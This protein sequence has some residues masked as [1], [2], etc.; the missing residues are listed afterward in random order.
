MRAFASRLFIPVYFFRQF[1]I[2]FI[3]SSDDM[4]ISLSR[5]RTAIGSLKSESFP[6][7]VPARQ[8]KG[9]NAVRDT[10]DRFIV[11]LTFVKPC[12]TALIATRRKGTAAGSCERNERPPGAGI[13]QRWVRDNFQSFNRA[14][15][16]SLLS[17]RMASVA[18]QRAAFESICCISLANSI[19][20]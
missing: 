3:S 8:S 10:S 2:R 5:K 14:W 16:A 7:D 12:V 6:S 13:G 19:P 20:S 1:K 15:T 11:F 18:I 17:S 9:K 4:D